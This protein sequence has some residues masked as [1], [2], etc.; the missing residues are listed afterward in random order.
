MDLI[1]QLAEIYK[2]KTVNLSITSK[3]NAITV[4]IQ[5]GEA[6]AINV[7]GSSEEMTDENFMLHLAKPLKE[8]NEI[9]SNIEK[10]KESV[11]KKEKEEIKKVSGKPASSKKEEKKE[12]KEPLQ[13]NLGGF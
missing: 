6:T 8:I 3:D 9:S 7:S 1:K 10:V 13:Q 11:S 5:S 2:D 12:E 4:S